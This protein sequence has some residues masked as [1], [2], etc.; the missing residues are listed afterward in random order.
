[1]STVHGE[2]IIVSLLCHHNV[3][4]SD[5]T[6]GTIQGLCDVAYVHKLALN[7]SV[8]PIHTLRTLCASPIP[9]LSL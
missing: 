4:S 9:V 1:M 8:I 7:A 5:A 2:A 3:K 6:C